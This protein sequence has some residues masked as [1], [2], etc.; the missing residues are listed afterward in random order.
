MSDLR[1]VADENIPFVQEAFGAF[2]A[3]QLKTG[4]ALGAADVREADVLLVRSV[5]RVDA[6]LLD[7]SGVRFVGSATI[8]TDHVDQDYLRR[9]GIAFAHAPGSNATSVVEYVLAALLHLAVTTGEALRG[10]TV[11]VVGCGNVGSRLAARLPAL[12]ARVLVNDPPLAERAEGAGEV[13]PFVPLPHL[14]A[15]ADVVSLHVPLE[16]T[17][18]HPTFHLLGTEEL[19]HM[20]SG[21]WL[22]N[23]ARGPVVSNE[24]LRHALKAAQIGA[25]VLD[26][27]EDEPTPDPALL[28]RVAL[29]TPHIAG[30]SF[31]GK[32]QG[33]IQLYDAFLDHFGLPRRWRPEVALAPTPEDHLT[34]DAPDPALPETAYLHALVRQMYDVADDDARL[35][36]LLSRPPEEH[37]AYFTHLRK[38]YPRRR[39]FARHHLLAAVPAAYHGAVEKGLLLREG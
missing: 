9:R 33:T 10:K 12:G 38:T 19:A 18:L 39:T 27:W 26:V 1:I 8:G 15:E 22:I 4:R 17:G 24:A 21:D 29:G 32:V 5:T 16:R 31:D 3:V 30:Y 6:G 25:A 2:G 13:R 11:G 14:L 36:L 28:H 34:L 35:R 23:T 20:K 37:A 7:G